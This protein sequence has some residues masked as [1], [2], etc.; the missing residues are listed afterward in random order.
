MLARLFSLTQPRVFVSDKRARHNQVL[1]AE[2]KRYFKHLVMEF[3]RHCTL[4][5][6]RR[7]LSLND[8]N[9]DASTPASGFSSNQWPQCLIN[10]ESETGPAGPDE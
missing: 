9:P 2:A 3:V 10:A 7:K 5:I 6:L 4:V 8:R 1:A